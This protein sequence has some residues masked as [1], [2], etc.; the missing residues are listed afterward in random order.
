MK[1]A[2]ISADFGV[3]IWGRQTTAIRWRETVAAL[4]A[5]GH[6]IW[7]FS[8]ALATA[9]GKNGEAGELEDA[10]LLPIPPLAHHLQFLK[11]FEA[12]DKLV[13]NKAHLLP[14]LSRL[15]YNLAL[16]EKALNY[17]RG[18]QIDFV[19]ERYSLFNH[20]GIRLARA[21]GVPHLLEVHATLAYEKGIICEALARET[22]HRL[23]LETDQVIV[24]SHELQAYALASG[25][26]PERIAILPNAV[27]PQ[28]FDPWRGDQG[29]AVRTQYQLTGKCIIGLA[30]SLKLRHGIET[31]LLA[32]RRL[33]TMV[34]NAHLLIVGDGPGQEELEKYAQ[35][36]DLNGMVTFT[37]GVPY[38]HLPHY[39]AAMDIAVAPSVPSKNFYDSSI[40]LLEYMAL[41]KP[42]VAGNLGEA[43][44][45]IVDGE[46]GVLYEPGNAAQLAAALAKLALNEQ[47][48]HPLGEKAR[49][50]VQKEQTWENNAKQLA[51]MGRR[52]IEKCGSARL[53]SIF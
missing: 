29:M 9:A 14:A 15:L 36:L 37:G 45:M 34:P 35:G 2:Y 44:A 49:A 50:W 21:L 10:M 51:A 6:A 11:E 43:Q 53:I 33:H 17:L 26:P 41:G 20:A 52:L 42:V 30:G 39:I 48:C 22:E 3:P 12:L 19:Y 46:T 25:V 47:P 27:N 16:Y 32:F 40:R 7:V 4:C 31:L 23:L 24:P 18:R 1:I 38:D 13:G 28:R 5:E 8:P